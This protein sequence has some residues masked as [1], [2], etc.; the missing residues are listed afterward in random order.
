MVRGRNSHNELIEQKIG[1][2]PEQPLIE[3]IAKTYEWIAK[4][5]D[6]R[7]TKPS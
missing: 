7:E 4:Q 5:V 3:G 6:D 1:W 2:K